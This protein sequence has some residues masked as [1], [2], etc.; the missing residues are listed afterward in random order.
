MRDDDVICGIMLLVVVFALI[1]TPVGVIVYNAW[2][3][4]MQKTDDLTSYHTKKEVEDTC[5]SY[6]VSYESDRM[7][8]EQY[9]DSDNTEQSSW[10]NNA[11]IRANKTA[12]A[13]N[14][15]ILKNNYVFQGNIPSDIRSELE[16]IK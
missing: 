3:Y 11:K 1:A 14:E 10:A 13:Y 5:R 9:K 8:Y 6:I 12:I 16:I 4:S 7:T 15:Y 2:D